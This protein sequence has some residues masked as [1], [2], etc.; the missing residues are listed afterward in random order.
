MEDRREFIRLSESIAIKYTIIYSMG[1]GSTITKGE[2]SAL[3]I[4]VSEGGLLFL[5]DIEL[6]V[7]TFLEIEL[8]LKGEELPVYLKG[9]VI[10]V[11]KLPSSDQYEVRMQFEYKYQQDINLLH[12]YVLKNTLQP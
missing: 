12:Q 3:S 10:D 2:G 11:L 6:P 8:N 7:K 1:F 9:E 5:S 4:N